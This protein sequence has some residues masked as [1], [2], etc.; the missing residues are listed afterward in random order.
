[1]TLTTDQVLD[2][3]RLAVITLLVT[4]GVAVLFGLWAV[5]GH[6]YG[7]VS[8]LAGGVVVPLGLA[9]TFRSRKGRRW[10][11]AAADWATERPGVN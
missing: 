6:L 3:Y 11:A 5:V 10:L 7:F 9:L 8:G 2:T 4:L 1:M